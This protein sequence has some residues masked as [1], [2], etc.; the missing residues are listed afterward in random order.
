MEGEVTIREVMTREYVGVSESDTV[1]GAV[2]LMHEEGTGSVIVLRGNDPI[3]IV[4]ESDVL[5][6]V[7]DG[8]DP[9]TTDV[10]TVMSRPVVS[11]AGD[12]SLSDAARAMTQQGIRRLLVTENGDLVGVLTERDVI[13]VSASLSSVSSVRDAESPVGL[14]RVDAETVTEQMA[15]GGDEEYTSQSICEACG[16]LTHD[17]VNVNGQL[18]CSDC[19][20]V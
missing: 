14:D 4:T 15:N 18:I 1:R 20:G 11:M 5:E 3:G 6:L 19:R 7:A 13:S 8:S 2:E 16:S 10:S 9:D 17:L 12:R